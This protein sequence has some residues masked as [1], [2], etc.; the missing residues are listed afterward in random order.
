MKAMMKHDNKPCMNRGGI[1]NPA[2]LSKPSGRSIG[3]F[4]DHLMGKKDPEQAQLDAPIQRPT[5]ASESDAT[6]QA[7][8]N[9]MMAKEPPSAIDSMMKHKQDLREV[10][11]YARGGIVKGIGSPTSDSV[12]MRI[13]GKDVNLSNTETVLPGKSSQALARMLGAEPGNEA[14]TIEAFIAE[15]NGKP[16]VK[17]GLKAGGKYA[18]GVSP[19]TDEEQKAAAAYNAANPL[20]AAAQY[21]NRGDPVKDAAT[22][23]GN[24]A[25]A[26]GDFFKKSADQAR[27]FDNTSNEGHGRALSPEAQKIT[28][29][30]PA[31][32]PLDGPSAPSATPAAPAV[33]APAFENPAAPSNQKSI[34][35]VNSETMAEAGS[36][37]LSNITPA[38]D[39]GIVTGTNQKGQTTMVGI[40]S[41]IGY[42]PVAEKTAADAARA[43]FEKS[44]ADVL[45]GVR[46]ELAGNS[47][48]SQSVAA[49]QTPEALQPGSVGYALQQAARP[50]SLRAAENALEYATAFPNKQIGSLRTPRARAQAADAEN[51]KLQALGGIVAA[52]RKQEN[53]IALGNLKSQMDVQTEGMKNATSRDVAGMQGNA[54]RDV[55]GISAE[56]QRDVARTR[57][58]GDLE[59]AKLNASSPEKALKVASETK[60]STLRDQFAGLNESNDPEGK[61][62]REIGR[63]IDTYSGKHDDGDWRVQQVVTGTDPVTMQPIKSTIA[64]NKYQTD[65]KTGGPLVRDLT[66]GQSG[67]AATPAPQAAIDLLKKNP[68]FADA[69]KQK[70][71]YLPQ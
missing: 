5:Y 64:V 55:A 6:T 18:A 1:I 38:K 66:G 61:K 39:S 59:V 4:V 40:G 44:Y 17:G 21:L 3:G 11:N 58:I 9:T 12:P 29:A 31:A 25:S 65:P 52:G 24:A 45:P 42:D 63:Q 50:S 8:P 30:P 60:L 10:S 27:G 71:G 37:G 46:A 23:I 49:P 70:Y 22:G 43:Q 28:M 67:A 56:G 20:P 57:G 48:A 34:G 69:F 33:Q 19:Y 68:G 2:G 7:T 26:V 14:A 54:S 15:T 41:P 35:K 53:D 13:A 51:A 36:M 16:P 62:R 32:V 47:P